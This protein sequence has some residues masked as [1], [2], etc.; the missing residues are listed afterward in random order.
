MKTVQKYDTFEEL[1]A[2][3]KNAVNTVMSIKKH[4]EFTSLLQTIYTLKTERSKSALSN[5][6]NVAKYKK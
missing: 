1:K 5:S 3:E 2:A 4:V 6:L